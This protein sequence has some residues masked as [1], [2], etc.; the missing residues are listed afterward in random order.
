MDEQVERQ[1]LPGASV[2]VARRGRVAFFERAGLRDREAGVPVTADTL[3][4]VF[5]MTKPLVS[6]AVLQ[7]YEQGDFQLDD[8]IERFL[9]ELADMQVMTGGDAA[10]PRLEPVAEPI[11]IRHLLTHTA[12][13]TYW[14][15]DDSPVSALYRRAGVDFVRGEGALAEMVRRLGELPLLDHPG[16]R[17]CYSVATDVLGRLLEVLSGEPLDVYLQRSV[18]AP[19]GMH[20]TG[21][22]VPDERLH[23]FAA[24]YGPPG[25][26][27]LLDGS[28]PA[29]ADGGLELLETPADSPF[30][31][32]VRLFSGGGG[33]ISTAPDYWRFCEMMRRGG[34]LDGV[35]L[36]GRKTV[37]Y[38]T[39]NHLPGDLT[40]MGRPR[41]S[42]TRYDGI[43]FG[44]GFSV[45]LDPV[46]AQILGSVGEY[47]WG[48][49]ASTAFWVDPA[50]ELVVLLLTQ[51]MPSWSYP[52]RQ[53]LRVLV[54]QALVE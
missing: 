39:R 37:A 23:R 13:L 25:S 49:V 52:L 9:P 46:R 45:M 47:G 31:A 53:Q 16:R 27:G 34:E 54:Y 41:F 42:E 40:A 11:T 36:L 21:F 8:P 24:L 10:A 15:M 22:S 3:F 2:L 33:L 44:L 26:T 30:R 6:V 50:E 38:M 4:R 29:P 7:R 48:G 28:G 12:G 17:W 35:R 51:L 32:P 20:D 18:L 5:S 14:F 1:R 19:L 43:G